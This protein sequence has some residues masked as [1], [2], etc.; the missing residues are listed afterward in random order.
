MSVQSDKVKR[1]RVR[2]KIR[3]LSYKGNKCEICGYDKIEYLS[4]FNFHHKDPNEKEFS[5]SNRGRC[6]SFDKLK[7]EADKCNLLC[8]RCHQEIHD[9]QHWEER[10]RLLSVSFKRVTFEIDCLFCGKNF[11][12]KQKKQKY[13][14][15]KCG[16]LGMR[17]QI[18]PST[19]ILLQEKKDIG[20]DGMVKKYNI[21]QSTIYNWLNYSFTS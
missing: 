15:A 11:K 12:Q 13:C 9:R 7:K 18:R 14:C 8:T 20:I 3:L 6:I 16:R 5:L 19:D 4:A 21:H 17:K 2:Q 10:G 1:W